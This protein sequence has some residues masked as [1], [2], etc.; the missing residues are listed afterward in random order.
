MLATAFQCPCCHDVAGV[1]IYIY[2]CIHDPLAEATY[3][4]VIRTARDAVADIG[5][6]AAASSGGLVDLASVPENKSERDGQRII[7]KAGLSLPIQLSL[8]GEE[9]LAFPILRLRFLGAI[10]S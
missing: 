8:L 3:R 5:A 7:Q 9:D 10:S 4:S 1:C 2:V 6:E